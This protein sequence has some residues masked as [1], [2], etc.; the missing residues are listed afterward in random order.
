MVARQLI[1]K[2]IYPR[3]HTNKIKFQM[4]IIATNTQTTNLPIIMGDEGLGDP[5]S[6]TAHPEHASF[7]EYQGV[8][9]YPESRVSKVFAQLR[10]GLAK[11]ARETD[12]I[13]FL[14]MLIVPYFLSFKE[15][16]TAIDELSS[17]EIQD[18]LEMQFETTDRQGYP[19]YNG[20]SMGGDAL[21]MGAGAMGLTT[22][23][24][25]E[26]VTFDS[27]L[28]FDAMQY[29]TIANK[30][31]A[32]CR[33]FWVT[34]TDRNYLTLRINLNSKLKRINPYTSGGVII[35]LPTE[36]SPEQL[37]HS[38]DTTN[39]NHI[40]VNFIYRYL[41]WNENFDMTKV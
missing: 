22:D 6:Y 11:P 9:C 34:V 26:G 19:L 14:R 20:A 1:K 13:K 36:T 38:A 10:L 15:D 41:E 4:G 17:T 5:A 3:P 28:M 32:C 7:A 12:K 8:N 29:M 27:D 30:L 18:V 2:T 21:E 23:T 33:A 31:K 25:L 37:S 24:T 16:Y 40:D 39:V 35:H